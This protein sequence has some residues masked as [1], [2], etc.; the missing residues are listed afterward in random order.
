MSSQTLKKISLKAKMS[1]SKDKAQKD[2]E[3]HEQ[4]MKEILAM[5]GSKQDLELLEGID[6][7]SEIEG[8]VDNGNENQDHS[9]QVK[10]KLPKSKSS[11]SEVTVEPKLQTELAIFMKSLFGSAKMDHR[12][13]DLAAEE[14]EEEEEEV[15]MDD[16][17]EQE[18]D[19]EHSE[20]SWE[21]EDDEENAED[22]GDDSMDDLPQELKEIHAQLEG[23]KRKAESTPSSP[24]TAKPSKKSKA[25]NLS[26]VSAPTKKPLPVGTALEKTGKRALKDIQKQVSVILKKPEQ[27]TAAKKDSKGSTKITVPKTKPSTSAPAKNAAKSK[28]APSS[29]TGVSTGWKLGDGWSK[30]FEDEEDDVE[31][32]K[33]KRR[34]SKKRQNSANGRGR[35]PVKVTR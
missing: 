31:S 22:S 4:F 30:A 15:E 23:K 33:S 10:N 3:K 25:D 20:G 19:V 24:A 35:T 34:P 8:D 13:M 11:K 2:V 9:K 18:D 16:N 21:T 32:G 7:D 29:S 28:S 12:K 26:S 17:G 1:T 5:G 14:E 27:Q 6:S